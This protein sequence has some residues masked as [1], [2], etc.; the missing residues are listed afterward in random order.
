MN[1]YIILFTHNNIILIINLFNNCLIMRYKTRSEELVMHK[2]LAGI[3]TFAVIS[4]FSLQ[5]GECGILD[6]VVRYDEDAAI[7]EIYEKMSP[8][9]V[10][11]EAD[12]KD[13]LSSGTGCIID[14]KGIILTPH[15]KEFERLA[16]S[17]FTG[18]YER[19]DN[20]RDMAEHL[21]AYI[22]LK[23]RY[24]ALCM[25]DGNIV[26]NSTGNSGM[27]TAGCGDVLTGILTGLL[28]RGYKQADAC[29]LAMYL[30]GLAGDMA[31]NDL[32]KE[33][34]IASDIIKYLPQ[35]FKSL[36]Y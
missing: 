19:L 26:F 35:A 6:N 14:P 7:T 10:L 12:V 28:A 22:I 5:K 31:A 24:T 29:M 20:A 17:R 13:G 27:A 32:G 15:P 33:C 1:K 23:G 3:L 11:I 25:P 8:A 4:I 16:G 34:L 21:H 36:G 30:H 18:C 9:I 2:I